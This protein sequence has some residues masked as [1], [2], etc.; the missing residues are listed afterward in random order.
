MEKK[1][2]IYNM[3]ADCSARFKE[4]VSTDYIKAISYDL[5]EYS[6]VDIKKS[7]DLIKRQ[8]DFFPSL[9][10]II[11]NID[12]STSEHELATTQALTILEAARNYSCYDKD[13]PQDCLGELWEVASM[14]GWAALTK[15]TDK[16]LNT[17]RAQLRDLCKAFNKNNISKESNKNLE[18][19]SGS[20]IEKVG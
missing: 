2:K 15:I 9:A 12:P 4:K 6:T 13:G 3:L 16:E 10:Q 11:K 17:T 5:E 19:L 14:F 20:I 1:A 8:S 18:I 7:L